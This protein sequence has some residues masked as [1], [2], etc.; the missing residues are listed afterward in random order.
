VY[1]PALTSH[2]DSVL[3]SMEQKLQDT[4]QKIDFVCT[5]TG[6]LFSMTVHWIDPAAL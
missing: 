5:T 6:L 3:V 2:L 1:S 4:L